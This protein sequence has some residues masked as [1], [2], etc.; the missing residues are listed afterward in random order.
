M[1]MMKWQA[2]SLVAL[3]ASGCF[4]EKEIPKRGKDS[5]TGGALMLD[6]CKYT[7]TTA[8]G[9]SRP[10]PATVGLGPD[11]TPKMVHLNVASDPRT[12]IAILWRTNDESTQSTTVQYG[13][14]G[15]L[16]QTQ[17]GFTFDYDATPNP[18]MIHET[19]LCGLTPDTEYSYRVGGQNGTKMAWSPVY[20]FRTLPDSADATVH[21][22]VIGDTRDGYST[23]G[24]ALKT[25]FQKG[26]PDIIL[27]SGD[28]TSLG[29]VQL[30]WDQWFLAGDPLLASTPMV[31]AHG[32]HEVNSVNFFSQFALPGDEQNFAVQFGPVHLTVANDTPINQA[33]VTG[34]VKTTLAA[35]LA[36][37][38]SAPWNLLMHHKPMFSAS[39]SSHHADVLYMRNAWE[40]TIDANRVDM[41]FNGHDHD[42]E[43]S[44]PMRQGAV[45]ADASQG[46][47]FVVVGA[48]GA[49]LYPSGRD[50]WTAV[51]E[52]TYSFALVDVSRKM[53]S[54]TAY[55]SDGSM[56]DSYMIAK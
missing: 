31:V 54:L 35:N 42:Y 27:F 13:T 50:F 29:P 33:D 40:E 7:V 18:V 20:T 2:F 48:A 14:N 51:S 49:D 15:K 53:L 32:N 19:H 46:T 41:V 47:V 17:V 21:M 56:L 23:W 6:Q 55:R 8:V 38:N 39:S 36:A 30:E 1:S 3:A 11:P 12:G 5:Y 52:S 25:A 43:R 45:Q 34:S 4:F 24:A 44:K 9:A 10:F 26:T 37:G 22:L 16:D 28:E